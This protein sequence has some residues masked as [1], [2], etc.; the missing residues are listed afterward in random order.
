MD[1]KCPISLTILIAG[2]II[3]LNSFPRMQDIGID[4]YSLARIPPL[5]TLVILIY[6]IFM[7]SGIVF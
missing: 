3:Q 1:V 6:N 2:Q 5:D 4:K 7:T